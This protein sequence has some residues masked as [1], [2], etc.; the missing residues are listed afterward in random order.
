MVG[1]DTVQCCHHHAHPK[2]KYDCFIGVMKETYAFGTWKKVHRNKV[3]ASG[4][5][6]IQNR[7]LGCGQGSGAK[8]PVA[9]CWF[10]CKRPLHTFQTGVG[11]LG[12]M[13]VVPS[14]GPSGSFNCELSC[15]FTHFQAPTTEPEAAEKGVP[16]AHLVGSHLGVRARGSTRG[17]C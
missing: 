9:S 15:L 8:R 3:H 4:E 2:D 1:T 11:P 13:T 7:F 17:R 16:L 6:R 14:R 10:F 5:S 12:I